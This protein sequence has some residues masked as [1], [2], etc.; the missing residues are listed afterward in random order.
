[1]TVAGNVLSVT[2]VATLPWH[3]LPPA[4]RPGRSDKRRL[5]TSK[6][7][8][9]AWRHQ[10]SPHR[11]MCV[12]I[13]RSGQSSSP[14]S[15]PARERREARHRRGPATLLDSRARLIPADIS[16][17]RIRMTSSRY[18]SSQFSAAKSATAT[19]P[20]ADV[21]QRSA[22]VDPILPPPGT[23]KGDCRIAVACQSIAPSHHSCASGMADA[24]HRR[25]D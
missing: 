10:L 8:Q 13:G 23:G 22:V 12:P 5:K 25:A 11:G 2:G 17:P 16:S 20:P 1:M 15:A 24:V 19:C 6:L 3:D 7:H 21:R 9:A 4:L 14:T 18:A